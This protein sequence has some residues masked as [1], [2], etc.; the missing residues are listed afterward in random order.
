MK[1]YRYSVTLEFN[2]AALETVKGTVAAT[3]APTASSRALKALFRRHPKRQWSSLV[4][5]LERGE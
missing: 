5:V 2:E 4:V 3:T 1:P